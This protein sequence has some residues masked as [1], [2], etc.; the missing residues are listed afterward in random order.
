MTKHQGKY[1]TIFDAETPRLGFAMALSE[2]SESDE[3]ILMQSAI[4]RQ[5]ETLVTWHLTVGLIW[6]FTFP[7]ATNFDQGCF[8]LAA[9][10]CEKLTTTLNEL[11]TFYHW[12]SFSAEVLPLE[13]QV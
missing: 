10:I 13:I 7:M 8:C 4:K 11:R 3:I 6:L 12:P 1:Y 2:V 9:E 5:R